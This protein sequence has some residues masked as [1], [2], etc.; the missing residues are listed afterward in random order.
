MMHREQMAM[1]AAALLLLAAAPCVGS[2][3]AKFPVISSR[4]FTGGSAEVSVTGAFT[5]KEDVAINTQASFGSG[6]K[7]WLQF[8]TAG[9]PEPNAMIT[10]GN[11]EVGVTV[12]RGKLL[13]T[14]GIIVGEK[15][16]CEGEVK[17]TAKL[18]S[19]R[20]KCRGVTSHDPATGKLGKVDI[21]VTFTA[22]S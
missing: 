22:K 18:I 8:G 14:G 21:A 20:Y 15:S 9:S 7:T 16:E 10:Y 13:A 11:N 12:A 3:Q 6:D 2:A 5:I 1:C 17:V 19:G 4:Q